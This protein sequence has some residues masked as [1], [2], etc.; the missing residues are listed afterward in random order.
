[1]KVTGEKTSR[2]VTGVKVGR[3]ELNTQE[4]IKKEKNMDMEF[5][6]G[7]TK[8]FMKEIGKRTEL[9]DL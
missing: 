5:M 4:I 1:M 8:A 2:K 3:M 9:R 6:N 7:Q